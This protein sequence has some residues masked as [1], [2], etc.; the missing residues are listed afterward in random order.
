MASENLS[1]EIAR[2]IKSQT[3]NTE[4]VKL[5]ANIQNH[6]ELGHT[7]MTS[8]KILEDSLVSSDGKS[9][10]IV[11][12]NGLAGFRRFY[13]QEQF[14][15]SNFS[16]ATDQ[17][18][19][20]D[21]LKSAIKKVIQALNLTVPKQLDL[22]WQA[23]LASLHKSRFLLTGGP[24]TGK[25]T[26]VIRMMLLSL[27]LDDS[28][29]IAL[30]APTG[31]AANQLMQSLAQQLTHVDLPPPIQKKLNTKAQTIH[32][33]LGYN[34]QTNKI[35]YNQNNP[36]PYDLIIIDE[37]SMLDVTLTYSLLKALKPKAQLLLI[38]DKNQLPAVEA[39]NVF[40]DLC[41]LFQ[42]ST[43]DQQ[44]N[45]LHEFLQDNKPD[46]AHINSIELTINYRFADNSLI[47]QMCAALFAQNFSFFT[48]LRKTNALDWSCPQNKAEKKQALSDWYKKITNNE[49]TVLLSPVNNGPNSTSELN[50][51]TRQILYNNT[52]KYQNM[53]IMVTQNDYA[54]GVFNGDVGT[55]SLID[56]QWYVALIVE[57]QQQYIQLNALPAW[58]QANAI[59]IHK[60]QGSEYDHV[61]I[62]IPEDMELNILTN[63]LFYTAI[64]R[65]KKTITVWSS[66]VMI[67]KI[68]KTKENRLTFLKNTN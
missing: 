8:D 57:G 40:A 43:S 39:G 33:L 56:N 32:R 21:Y 51:I 48:E 22:Q 42:D 25:T 63:A 7:A 35:K 28:K 37:S 19:D 38:G 13:N 18:I 68:I 46:T 2:F 11:Q 67:E 58:E 31:K 12:Q 60:S 23:C 20:K 65:A 45:L 52:Y 5:A 44:P 66:D 14:I 41:G 54:L 6:L 10:Y 15:K 30:S 3:T 47:G 27:Y 64:S 1:H 9:G 17:K 29:N 24:G 61:L 4:V 59:T 26:T 62:A 34:N 16:H 55:L 36:L 50:E 53:P 49:T